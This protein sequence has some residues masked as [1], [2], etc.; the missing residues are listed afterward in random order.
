MT[1]GP[2][3]GQG[4]PVP[5]SGARDAR[6]GTRR[7]RTGDRSS[8]RKFDSDDSGGTSVPGRSRVRHLL[9]MLVM[10][11]CLGGIL[12]RLMLVQGV[13]AAK[14]QADARSEYVHENL[15]PW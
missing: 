9:A 2:K 14:Y 6:T 4:R 3:G 1:S 5:A 11:A 12:A 10:V 7:A 13:D 8:R 15:V